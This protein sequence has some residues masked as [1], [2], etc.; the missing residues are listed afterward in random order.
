MSIEEFVSTVK[1][2][3]EDLANS[4]YLEF[5]FW[6]GQVEKGATGGDS[7]YQAGS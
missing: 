1:E 5:C 3:R 7:F 2:A 6:Y 4:E